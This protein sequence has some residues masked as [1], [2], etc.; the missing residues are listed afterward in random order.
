MSENY[1]DIKGD[2]ADIKRC[3][4]SREEDCSNP[5]C[6]EHGQ[7]CSDDKSVDKN[8]QEVQQTPEQIIEEL[9]QQI[10][11]LKDQYI[12][13]QADMQN[14]ERRNI[15]EVKKARDYAI[16]SFAGDIVIVKDYLEMALKDQSGNFEMLKMG[17]DLTL[18]Q[19]IQVFENHKVKTIDP[20]LG[21]KLDPNLHQAMDSIDSTEYESGSI[22]EILQKGYS[23]N[24]R[25]LRPSMVKVAK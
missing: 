24:E 8:Q 25:V 3:D 22:A 16:S 13:A 23:L 7:T 10:A 1:T 9:H 17:V 11:E 15:E 2:D 14:R 4:R 21:D 18:K 20:K 5:V 12:R 19:L 6:E